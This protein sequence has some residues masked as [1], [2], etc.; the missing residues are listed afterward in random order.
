MHILYSHLIIGKDIAGSHRIR[1][2]SRRV[3]N[4]ASGCERFEKRWYGAVAPYAFLYHHEP[5][6]SQGKSTGI[7]GVHW[8][9]QHLVASKRWYFFVFAAAL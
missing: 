8:Y 5:K 7:S 9:L 2:T 1:Q 4:R 3:G 6:F